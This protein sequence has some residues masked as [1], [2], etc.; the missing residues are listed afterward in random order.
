MQSSTEE[1][2]AKRL[3]DLYHGQFVIHYRPP[4][5]TSIRQLGT[6]FQIEVTVLGNIA[7]L[8]SRVVKLGRGAVLRAGDQSDANDPDLRRSASHNQSQYLAVANVFG[9][10]NN[11]PGVPCA[12]S[13]C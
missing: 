11:W 6:P 2:I 4:V 7:L 13:F 3:D 9:L 12:G 10:E 5:D 1:R 8:H